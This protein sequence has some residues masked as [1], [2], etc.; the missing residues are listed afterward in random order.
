MFRSRKEALTIE[1]MQSLR[2]SIKIGDIV[3]YDTYQ[4]CSDDERL[5]IPVAEPVIVTEKYPYLVRVK[6]RGR[7]DDG[8]VRTLTYVDIAMQRI[9]GMRDV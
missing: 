6:H 4:Y 5:L 7:K 9:G 8:R 2:A 3:D 1:D